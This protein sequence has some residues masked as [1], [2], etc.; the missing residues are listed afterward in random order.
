MKGAFGNGGALRFYGV[1]DSTPALTKTISGH[2]WL[3]LRLLTEKRQN[4]FHQRV[5]S[6][7]VLLAQDWNGAVLDELIGPA[8]ACHRCIDHLRV[9]MFHDCAAET[10]VQH[11]VF[12]RTDH[13]D[14]A[15]KEFERAAI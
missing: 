9:E 6:D 15:C 1:L 8:D 2:R 3:K 12:D 13:F 11:V 7:A 5:S 10:V 4:F 14:A